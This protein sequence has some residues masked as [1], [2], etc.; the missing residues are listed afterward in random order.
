MKQMGELFDELKRRN[1]LRVAIAYIVAAWL[2]LQVAD[3][4]L[5]NIEAPGWVFQVILLLVALGFPFA[6]IFAWAYELTPEGLKK[7][8]DVDRSVSITHIT[9]RKLDFIIMAVMVLALGY[10]A[11]DKFVLDPSR[12]AELV[13][14]TTEAVTEQVAESGNA[15]TADHS[16]AVLPFANRSN[17]E[18]DEFFTEGIHD[19]LLSTIAKISSMKV[20]SRTSVMQYKDTTKNI[21][22]I[23]QE[24]GVESILEGG[25]QRSGNKVRINVQLI[26]AVADKHLWAKIYDRELTAENLF[27]IQS[28][29]SKA[30]AVALRA[31]LSPEEQEKVDAVHTRNLEAYESYLLGRKLWTARTAESN[32]ESVKHFQRAIDLDP[33]YALAYV[34]LS[35]AYRFKVDYEGISPGE[36]FPLAERALQMALHLDDQLGEAYASRGALKLNARDYEGAGVDFLLAIELSPNHLPSYNWYAISLIGR[37]RYEDALAI[38]EKGLELDPLST[39]LRSNIWVQLQAAGRF[40]EARKN[41]ERNI[42]MHP[43][44]RF[45]YAGCQVVSMPRASTCCSSRYPSTTNRRTNYPITSAWLTRHY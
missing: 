41:Y 27:A 20:I 7:E 43:D 11:F 1:V 36:V 32:A 28:E 3:V 22:D 9:G 34:G 5:N 13:Q 31:T 17:R 23:A 2:L 12:D 39:I 15:E 26:D 37:G 45:G 19:D 6:L 44:A 10:F 4:V 25:I 29:I 35:D 30:I 40:D 38:F 14:T 33:D 18:E 8:K 21:R 24:L 42:E 16:I